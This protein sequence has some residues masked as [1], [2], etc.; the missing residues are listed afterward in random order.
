MELAAKAS[1]E[2]DSNTDVWRGHNNLG[3]LLM[4]N[5]DAVL[6]FKRALPSE[7][8]VPAAERNSWPLRIQYS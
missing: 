1:Q 6:E 3:V 8:S 4:T 5:M 7:E 2:H